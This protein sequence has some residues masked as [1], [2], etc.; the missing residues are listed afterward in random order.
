MPA[1]PIHS[2]LPELL[3]AL[4]EQTGAV[5][6][7][8]PGA[9]KTTAVAPA[10]LDQDWCSG[11]IILTSPRRVAARAAAERMAETLG[12][13]PGETIGYLTRLDSKRSARTRVLVVTEAIFV[14][15]IL[16]DPELSGISAVLFDEA[17]ERH[18]DS[19]LG[20]ALALES[21]AVLREDLRVLVMSATIDGSRFARLLGEEAPVIES[22]GRAYPLRIEW[23][24]S[25]PQAAVEDAMAQAI[26]SAWRQEEGDILA[27]LPGVREI[28]RTR[29]RLEARLPAALLLPLHGQVDPVGQRAA[30]KRDPEGRRRVVLA[31][32][33]AE[34]SLTL[35]GV[36]VVVDAGLSR[37]AEF[38]RVAGTT[39]L[40]TH[41]ASQA[42]AAQRAGRA[43]RQG[44]G[45]AYR[46][47]EE[48]GHAGRP[49]YDPPEMVTADLAPLVLAL[50]QWGSGDPAD[51]AWLDPP[52]EA[53]IGAAR[54]MLAALDALDETGRITP[55]GSKLA[56]L[57]L[58]P[59]GAATV[60]F[61][62]EHGAA[63]HAARLA[64]LLQERGLGGP[65]EDLEARLTRWNA[66]RGRR[67]DA[68]RR[69]AGRWAK[70][71][72]GL[73]GPISTGN[74]PPSAI[75]LAAGRPEFIAKRRDASGAQWL[76]AGGRGFV[77]DP[78]S[79]LARAA[80]MVVGDAQGQAKGARI[81]SGIALE[82]IELER[83]LSDRIE[84]RQ[85]LRWTGDRVE[86]LLERRLGAIT[87]ARGP[88]PAPDPSAIVDMLVEKALENPAKL[89]PQ[90]LLARA[91]HAGIESLSSV[92]LAATAHVWL[93]PLLQGRR[94][95]ALPKGKLVDAV[96]GQIDW[97]SRQR[98]DRLAP[99]A[100]TSPAGTTHEI[101]YVGDDAPSVEVRVQALFGL[102]RH[103]M[104]GDTPLLLKLTSPAG[105]PIQSTRDLPGFWR[106][107]WAEVRK[108][109]KGRY[110]KHRWP[111]EPWTE[112]PS[113]KT[114]NAFDRSR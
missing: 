100:F 56:Q 33:I 40:V 38:D 101:D 42:A 7:A 103:P 51:L 84:R 8:P 93:A 11:T 44:P 46:L 26:G 45:V 80:F 99:R 34:T 24:G 75:L 32:A 47:W 59:Q 50:A 114:R 83:W 104:V 43:A 60:L 28:E 62:A 89:L 31:T 72:T 52:P 86:A 4:R 37:R 107:S 77:L 69:L 21:R 88:D 19:D 55:R 106:G 81:T 30:I 5:L 65:G 98:L 110:P 12:E 90:A 91:G 82:E 18:L 15:T 95:L 66:D 111:E 54:Q 71:A 78:T 9:G 67:A 68:S 25:S 23:L 41:R 109:M 2:V 108:E 92:G 112:A 20:L 102:E 13:K 63:E 87:L 76:A 22:A 57:P 61:G 79:P 10:L 58:D 49:A 48:A 97:D 94:D 73:A 53:S 14:N 85:V 17:H 6:V 74:A 105:R 64:L 36:S 1:L 35:D 70:R 3:D 29:E 39:H 27:F 96:L 16:A 113:L